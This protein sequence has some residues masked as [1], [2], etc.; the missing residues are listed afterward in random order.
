M[1]ERLR[2]VTLTGK[3]QPVLTLYGVTVS[4]ASLSAEAYFLRAPLTRLRVLRSTEPLLTCQPPRLQYVGGEQ[5]SIIF[6]PLVI[7]RRGGP[8]GGT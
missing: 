8:H 5:Q 1:A 4:D 6:E 7:Q 3:G 2:S